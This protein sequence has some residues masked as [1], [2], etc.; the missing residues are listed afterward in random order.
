MRKEG[1]DHG[2]GDEDGADRERP[3]QRRRPQDPDGKGESHDGVRHE[4][5]APTRGESRATQPPAQPTIE[6]GR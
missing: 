1:A 5:M 4:Q 6:T 2:Q 3:W